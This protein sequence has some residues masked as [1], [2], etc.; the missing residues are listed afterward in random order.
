MHGELYLLQS[1]RLLQT[2]LFQD[3]KL[4]YKGLYSNFNSHARTQAKI[5]IY[6]MCMRPAYQ[7]HFVA[8]IQHF[9]A[10]LNNL[11]MSMTA[12]TLDILFSCG[13]C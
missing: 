8:Q 6:T 13:K 4:T 9:A 7:R 5:L 11:S 12:V 2:S 1:K 10:Q 3:V